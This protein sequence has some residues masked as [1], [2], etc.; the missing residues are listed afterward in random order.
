MVLRL[1]SLC[2]TVS[3]IYPDTPAGKHQS[4]FPGEKIWLSQLGSGIHHGPI[5]YDHGD[6]VIYFKYDCSGLAPVSW[7]DSRKEWGS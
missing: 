4:Q 2:R 1:P 7:G 3:I 6:M 5:S